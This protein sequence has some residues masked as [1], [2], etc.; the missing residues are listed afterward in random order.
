MNY[1]KRAWLSVT[2]R[3]VKS[4]LL[5]VI[6]FILGN[7]IAGA[8]SIQ[9]AT[10]NVERNIKSQM[11]ATA[12]I[13]TD[14]ENMKDSDW[15]KVEPLTKDVV[16][17]VS[18]LPYVKYFDYS[19]GGTL[20]A[21]DG[22]QQY[23]P[24]FI[25]NQDMGG[26]GFP[27]P[28]TYAFTLRGTQTPKLI[29]L[30]EG[31]I[32]LTSGRQFTKEEI[33]SGKAVVLISEQLAELN[34]LKVGDTA[35]FKNYIINYENNETAKET[36]YPLEIVG[37][38]RSNHL[39]AKKGSNDKSGSEQDEYQK[40]HEEQSAAN[41]VYVPN[42]IAEAIASENMEIFAEQT[43]EEISTAVGDI[44]Q[45]VYVLKNPDD[46]EKFK[47]EA[48]AY[49]PQFYIVRANSDNYDSIAGPVKSMSKLA[50]YVLMVA[51]GATVLIITLVVLLFLRDRKHELGIYLSLGESRGKVVLQTLAE[52]FMI[53][54][55]AITLA[56]FTG[57][58]IAQA[59]SDTLLQHQLN[60]TDHFGGVMFGGLSEL[61]TNTTLD[62]VVSQYKV[63]LSA[64]Y[65]LL[66]YGIGLGTV[67]LATIVPMAYVTR[68]NPKRI[69]M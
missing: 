2:R 18:E 6:I 22:L 15:E 17:K 11:G 9:Q 21:S 27:D 68:L 47:Q 64:G 1:L 32:S 40:A 13:Q 39:Q 24:E 28:K 48:K 51:I 69:M 3:K 49:L 62:D 31:L 25:A 43:G 35:T 20:G 36:D 4:L 42:Q 52:V 33:S 45:P 61:N 60:Q 57:N 19:V 16:T 59:L 38:F 8:V 50:G 30:E 37:I 29:P 53:A 65:M 58:L 67:L 10:Q 23:I 34:N 56:V 12:T 46:L 66:M 54:F 7:V 63:T 55:V 5:F 41:T 14:Y 44:G 26:G